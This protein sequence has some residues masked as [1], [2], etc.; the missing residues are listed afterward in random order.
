MAFLTASLGVMLVGINALF[1]RTTVLV[2]CGFGALAAF[3]AATG[4]ADINPALANAQKL[5]ARQK[6][7]QAKRKNE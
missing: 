6:S 2:F 5:A 7:E 1:G 3:V 4:D